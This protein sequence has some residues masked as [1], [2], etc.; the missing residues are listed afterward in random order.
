MYMNHLN[1][2]IG[3]TAMVFLFVN[4]FPVTCNRWLIRGMWW[5][6]RLEVVT[7]KTFKKT[8]KYL[9]GKFKQSYKYDIFYYKDNVNVGQNTLVNLVRNE[10]YMYC[11]QYN[12]VI[13]KTPTI[14]PSEYQCRMF[15]THEELLEVFYNNGTIRCEPS[16][17]QIVTACIVIK[18]HEDNSYSKDVTPRGLGVETIMNKLYT[19]IFIK[20]FFDI[21]VPTCYTVY[22]ID[23]KINQLTLIN[24]E[25][26]KQYLEI[27]SKGFNIVT[28]ENNDEN[29]FVIDK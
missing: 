15:D 2:C 7:K 3:L 28:E 8:Y 1:V 20:H 19:D 25:K 11:T 14:T 12:Y 13:Y 17:T 29:F 21:D 22:I 26:Q 16:T 23:S 27:T 10:E 24:N 5:Y 9:Y 18:D 6:C 4:K